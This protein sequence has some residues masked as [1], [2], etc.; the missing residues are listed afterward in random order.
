M[1]Q[2]NLLSN[3][4]AKQQLPWHTLLAI[5]VKIL[6]G[7]VIV[8]LAAWGYFFY[9]HRSTEKE[10]FDTQNVIKST[11]ETLSKLPERR[12]LIAR[13]GQLKAFNG[14]LAAQPHWSTFLT[15]RLSPVTLKTSRYVSINAQDDGRLRLSVSVPTYADL[16]KFLQIFDLPELN[17]VFSDIK[18]TSLSKSQVGDALDIRFDVSMKYDP[19]A[20]QLGE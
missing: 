15:T 19:T 20:I 1:A 2:I 5:V 10:I 12:E 11:S 14:Q 13:Q 7:I 17:K 8:M 16:D 6:S 3:Q 18:V 9:A 4:S